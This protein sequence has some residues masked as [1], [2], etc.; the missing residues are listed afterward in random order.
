M[1]AVDS[2]AV[3]VCLSPSG[4]SFIQYFLFDQ[5]IKV[6]WY[7]DLGSIYSVWMTGQPPPFVIFV[8][9]GAILHRAHLSSPQEQPK[10]NATVKKS[11]A[12]LSTT[13]LDHQGCPKVRT[14]LPYMHSN[15]HKKSDQR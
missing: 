15:E 13:S 4:C 9:L 3:E 7:L 2:A 5:S 6:L 11:L 12:A 10:A 14:T 8:P 1:N